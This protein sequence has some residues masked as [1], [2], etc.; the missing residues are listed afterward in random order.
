M[1]HFEWTLIAGHMLLFLFPDW[2]DCHSHSQVYEFKIH[3]LQMFSI[4]GLKCIV[5]ACK[6][7]LRI[8][9]QKGHCNR[10]A[11]PLNETG[12]STLIPVQVLPIGPAEGVGQPWGL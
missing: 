4:N 10:L 7:V 2:L 1:F 9:M 11:G 3:F 12:F 8:Q 6:L 5:L